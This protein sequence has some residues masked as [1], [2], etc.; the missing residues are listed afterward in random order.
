MKVYLKKIDQKPLVLSE[1]SLKE[2]TTG[3]SENDTVY[4]QNLTDS[5]QTKKIEMTSFDESFN[6]DLNN[7]LQNKNCNILIIYQI[8]LNYYIINAI[9]V[10]EDEYNSLSFDNKWID[11]NDNNDAKYLQLIKN[12]EVLK[13]GFIT[14]LKHTNGKGHDKPLDQKTRDYYLRFIDKIKKDQNLNNVDIYSYFTKEKI[15]DEIN[16][17]KSNNWLESLGQ[18]ESQRYYNSLNTYNRFFDGLSIGDLDFNNINNDIDD[19]E[20]DLDEDDNDTDN[21]PNINSDALNPL[22]I[23]LYGAP[24]TG[25]TYSTVDY[26]LAIINHK[27]IKDIQNNADNDE[28]RK[29]K[30]NEYH[31]N[32][33]QYDK[34][35]N[36]LKGYIAFTT[37][38][39]SYTYEDFIEGLKPDIDNNQLKFKWQAGIFKKIA[40]Q[41]SNDRSH[42]YV[43]IIDEINR[44][45]MSRVLGELITLLEADKRVDKDKDNSN[46]LSVILPSGKKFSV[47]KNLYIIGTMN[48][49]DKSISN[50]DV[51]LRR[52]FTFIEMPVKSKIINN[53]VFEDVLNAINHEIK[54]YYNENTDLLIG[55]AYFMGENKNLVD[56]L[57]QSIIPL[58]YEYFDDNQDKVKKIIDVITK[59]PGA[60]ISLNEN[61][62][63]RITVK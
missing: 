1:D 29:E 4:L 16:Q 27:S 62:Y 22:N 54:E 46:A 63:G 11:T 34:D 48:T 41:A 17:L 59:V 23:I 33:I 15:D 30:M 19:G 42:N 47:P 21:F 28:S 38:H 44:A 57:N 37:F 10:Q 56:I 32:E 55:Q 52:R 50:I 61:G 6:N 35:G 18:R 53:Q 3:L 7:F 14:W 60:N 2:F 45:N 8:K 13:L 31:E 51:A 26:A 49:A 43:I 40:D 9:K 25:K 36:Y 39:Q 58:L 24:G 12:P 20:D 5:E